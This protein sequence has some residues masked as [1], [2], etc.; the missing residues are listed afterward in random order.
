M[1]KKINPCPV[2][3]FTQLVLESATSLT[4]NLRALRRSMANCSSCISDGDC[5]IL[6][7]FNSKFATALQQVTDE[8]Q[9]T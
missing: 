1:P 6:A 7:D 9:L 8:W 2:Q 3:P 4:K 5:P